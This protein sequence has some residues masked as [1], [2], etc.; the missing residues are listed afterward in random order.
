VDFTDEELLKYMKAAHERDMTFNEFVTQAI[1]E[2]I[3]VHEA[4]PER[5]GQL[6]ND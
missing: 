2:A 3:R 4:D 1:T 5:F 6:Y